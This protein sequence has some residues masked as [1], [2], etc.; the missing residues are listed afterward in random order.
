MWSAESAAK[1]NPATT[2]PVA[3]TA[4]MAKSTDGRWLSEIVLFK[5]ST[6]VTIAIF[7][8]VVS[9]FSWPSVGTTNICVRTVDSR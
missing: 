6:P 5:E 2:A 4:P 7:L 9:N 3:I 1:I 8:I